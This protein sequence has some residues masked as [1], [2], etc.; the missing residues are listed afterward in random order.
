MK[1]FSG[2]AFSPDERYFVYKY[3]YWYR[4]EDP[5]KTETPGHG[6]ELDDQLRLYDLI[7]DEYKVISNQ[8]ISGYISGTACTGFGCLRWSPDSK[9]IYYSSSIYYFDADKGGTQPSQVFIARY[10]VETNQHEIVYQLPYGNCINSFEVSPDGDKIIIDEPMGEEEFKKS[11]FAKA[12]S[13]LFVYN[14]KTK[15]R[16][17]INC[18]SRY[19][20]S[21]TWC[22]DS[23]HFVFG[24]TDG[25]ISYLV[26][27]PIDKPTQENRKVLLSGHQIKDT[28]YSICDATARPLSNEIVINQRILSEYEDGISLINW[29]TGEVK[30]GVL[31]AKTNL[32]D[33]GGGGNLRYLNW[34]K[35]GRFLTGYISYAYRLGGLSWKPFV[36]DFQEKKVM[37]IA[38]GGQYAYPNYLIT[39]SEIIKLIKERGFKVNNELVKREFESIKQKW[40][41]FSLEQKKYALDIRI[42]MKMNT[43]SPELR[44]EVERQL[45]EWE[46]ELKSQS[47]KNTK[48][49]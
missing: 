38:E 8:E 42:T 22:Q 20:G 13:T 16:T 14:L 4:E 47:G 41:T 9:Y 35:D 37:Y 2:Y 7:L 19:I 18:S 31:Y 48:P 33:G 49:K 23:Q 3:D 30:K 21:F 45:R 27:T 29:K 44:E 34:S 5:T 12:R 36:I 39:N 26:V 46:A 24:D 43:P 25:E 1:G 32:P 17:R 6:N 11:G 15:T 40:S 28:D 10:D